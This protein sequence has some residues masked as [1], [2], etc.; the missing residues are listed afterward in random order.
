MNVSWR[1]SPWNRDEPEMRERIEAFG[2]ELAEACHT[3]EHVRRLNAQ[4]FDTD[5]QTME[6]EA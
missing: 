5:S 6:L 4:I 2:R 1:K 3:Y